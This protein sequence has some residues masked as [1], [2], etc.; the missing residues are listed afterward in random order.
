MITERPSFVIFILNR[1]LPEVASVQIMASQA[2]QLPLTS[3]QRKYIAR[4]FLRGQMANIV[5]EREK[6]ELQSNL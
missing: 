5:R 6:N 4:H 2:V 3:T 1:A